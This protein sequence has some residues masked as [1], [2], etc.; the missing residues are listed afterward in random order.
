MF[1]VKVVW[2]LFSLTMTCKSE[3]VVLICLI[4]VG[5]VI[6]MFLVTPGATT[7]LT[8]HDSLIGMALARANLAASVNSRPFLDKMYDIL[9]GLVRC[10]NRNI[11][12]FLISRLIS[13]NPDFFLSL[14]HLFIGL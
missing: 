5:S 10:E 14:G 13:F 8:R 9:L 11:L 3:S 4:C 6:L 12:S 7:G 1:L 2:L